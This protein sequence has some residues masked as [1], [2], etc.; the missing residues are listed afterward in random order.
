MPQPVSEE[1]LQ[2]AKLIKTIAHSE[3]GLT[4][5]KLWE[6]VTPTIACEFETFKD[7]LKPRRQ[8][9]GVN[10]FLRCIARVFAERWMPSSERPGKEAEY[11]GRMHATYSAATALKEPALTLPSESLR[12]IDDTH[13]KVEQLLAAFG[14]QIEQAKKQGVT[15]AALRAIISRI[16][17]QM[18]NAPIEDIL[19]TIE[20]FVEATLR[21][22]E[23]RNIRSNEVP[24]LVSLRTK[25]RSLLDSGQLDEVS[26]PFDAELQ[27]RREAR[28]ERAEEELRHDVRLLEEAAEYDRLTF[29]AEKATSRYVEAALL[30]SP[31]DEKEQLSY[32]SKKGDA[33]HVV[34]G[35]RGDTASLLV[36]VAIGRAVI[37]RIDRV[38]SPL[39][40]G[41]TQN[42]IA[43][44]LTY[45]GQQEIG[46]TRIEEAIGVCR[47][48]LTELT[49]ERAPLYWAAAQNTLGI[50]LSALGERE[51]GTKEN[52]TE[53]IAC[54]RQTLLEYTRKLEPIDWAIT[55][56]N[57]ANTL[58]RL[59]EHE[60]GTKQLN[61]AIACFRRS[62]KV[63]TRETRPVEWAV[64]KGH[65]GITLFHLGERK[66]GTEELEQAVAACREALEI[67]PEGR[68]EWPAI[69]N[70]LGNA[71]SALGRREGITKW[72][73][74]AVT[75]YRDALNRTS[76]EHMPRFWTIV[77]NNL[78]ATE[79][80]LVFR[81]D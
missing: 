22:R 77:K 45:L 32:L 69:K 53:A 19:R 5:S 20:R 48:A 65:L 16:E 7:Y 67:L 24:N 54:Y 13:S 55:Q 41:M 27:T 18:H 73:E 64:T 31:Q 50:A 35:T 25:A 9:T 80:L 44:I 21:E 36:A 51:G 79:K 17:A 30:L 15:E 12:K 75:A 29:N 40:W 62:L 58:T 1:W 76:R 34:G 52:L 8:P 3:T 33:L 47:E 10:D 28:S 6:K 70:T 66:N 61:E 23:T 59:S 57:L 14:S 11:F 38:S 39:S 71:L 63:R 56:F 60:S 2:T 74:E 26:S 46:I 43:A 4:Q 72:L 78:A 68:A 42:G 81:A 37:C 49:R